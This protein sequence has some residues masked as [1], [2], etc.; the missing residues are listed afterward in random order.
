M[1]SAGEDSKT[2]RGHRTTKDLD[3]TLGNAVDAN[4]SGDGNGVWSGK[5]CHDC[6]CYCLHPGVG[7]FGVFVLSGLM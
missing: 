4:S 3:F 5:A 1:N 7:H 6:R 2:S